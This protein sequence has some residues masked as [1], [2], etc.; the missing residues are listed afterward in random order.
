MQNT[1]I[2][3]ARMLSEW[4]RSMLTFWT[5]SLILIRPRYGLEIKREI[6]ESTQK[7]MTL[8]AGT[9]YQLLH[10]LEKNGLIEGHWEPSQQGP[11]RAYYQVTPA[12][13]EVLRRYLVEVFVPGSPIANALGQLMPQLF[14]QFSPESLADRKS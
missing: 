8:G 5:L 11:P 12:G 3:I 13:R 14:Q 9:L 2:L 10:R 1:E 7:K 4:K 6:E